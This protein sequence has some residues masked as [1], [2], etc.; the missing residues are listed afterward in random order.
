[1]LHPT[2]WTEVLRTGFTFNN[3]ESFGAALWAEADVG[4]SLAIRAAF[5]DAAFLFVAELAEL[6]L[7]TN[8]ASKSK[9]EVFFSE[10]IEALRA[11]GLREDLEAA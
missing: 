4:I 5:V 9:H 6:G 3:F 8:L 1:V 10:F 7:F 11:D 2:L